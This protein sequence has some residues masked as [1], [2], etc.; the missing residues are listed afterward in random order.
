MRVVLWTAAVLL[1]AASVCCGRT[2]IEAVVL[3]ESGGN[4]RAVGDGGRSCG[5]MQCGRA[6]WADACQA[7]G[8]DWDYDS[9]VWSRPHSAAVFLAYTT[10]WG[11]RTDEE[12]ARCWNSGPAWRRK[13]RL[14]DGYWRRVAASMQGD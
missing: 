9:L 7:L 13:Y 2:L 11:A 4:D 10:R 5:P 12:R 14:T 8:V 1:L 6:A 3:V